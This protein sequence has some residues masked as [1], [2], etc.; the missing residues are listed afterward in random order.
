M[1]AEPATLG[2]LITGYVLP[3][4]ALSAIG[5][6]LG[7]LF[8]GLG[9]MFALRIAIAGLVMALVGVVVL[10]VIIDALAPTFGAAKSSDQRGQ[11]RRLRAD[12]GVGRQA[13]FR[14]SRSSGSL[15]A[16]HRRALRL[17]SAVPRTAARDEEPAGQGGR[18]H[19]R[20]RRWSAIVV[21]FVV[22]STSPALLGFGPA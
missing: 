17:V 10:S 1:P 13:S 11:G 15:I 18:L 22:E 12:A 20:R 14:S 3:L 8:L 7:S 21:G 19:R 5:S 2:G 16:L 6:L 4:A 9:L